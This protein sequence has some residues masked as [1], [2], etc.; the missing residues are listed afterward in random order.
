[1]DKKYLIII[2]DISPLTFN[3]FQRYLNHASNFKKQRC[4]YQNSGGSAFFE[5]CMLADKGYQ[6]FHIAGNAEPL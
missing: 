1:M 4:A 3:S 2:N 6:S 5:I